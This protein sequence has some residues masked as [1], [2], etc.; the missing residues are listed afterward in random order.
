MFLE[1][2]SACGDQPATCAGAVKDVL[3]GV[4]CRRK[5]ERWGGCKLG[6]QPREKNLV[7]GAFYLRPLIGRELVQSGAVTRAW[8]ERKT[9]SRRVL[10]TCSRDWR[11]PGDRDGSS[12]GFSPLSRSGPRPQRPEPSQ[13]VTTVPTSPISLMSWW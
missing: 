9:P 12:P 1:G 6:A 5:S 8:S 11:G 2:H 7:G 3:G 10:R 4:V 13:K